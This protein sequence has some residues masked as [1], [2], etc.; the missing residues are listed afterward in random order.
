MYELVVAPQK[1]IRQSLANVASDGLCPST[2]IF[3]S[4]G[5]STN[6]N[7]EK[8]K[9]NEKRNTKLRSAAI[10]YLL[11]THITHPLI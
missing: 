5:I 4:L 11:L 8:K 6:S 9:T 10:T 7:F 2:V 3:V 1:V